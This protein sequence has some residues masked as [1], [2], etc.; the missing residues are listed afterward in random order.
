MKL[1]LQIK[2]A[3]FHKL[4]KIVVDRDFLDTYVISGEVAFLPFHIVVQ[5]DMT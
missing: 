1:V 3:Y 5:V 4:T 2:N